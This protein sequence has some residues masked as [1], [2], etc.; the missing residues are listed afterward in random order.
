M[1]MSE[2]MEARVL[3]ARCQGTMEF[4]H[5]N[6]CPDSEVVLNVLEQVGD[7]LEHTTPT[8]EQ[9]ASIGIPE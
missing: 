1:S 7:F 8:S 2:L 4:L 9:S 5:E 6:Y 3:L